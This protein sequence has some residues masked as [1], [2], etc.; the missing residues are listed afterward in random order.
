MFARSFVRCV[1][2]D[3]PHPL[4]V[5]RGGLFAA[6]G[7]VFGIVLFGRRRRNKVEGAGCGDEM[8]DEKQTSA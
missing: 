4:H 5:F 2:S 3:V 6:D 8:E 1:Y 7:S